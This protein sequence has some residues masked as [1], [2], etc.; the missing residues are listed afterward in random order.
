MFSMNEILEALQALSRS[1]A[2]GNNGYQNAQGLCTG[3]L[4]Q[5][6]SDLYGK[7]VFTVEGFGIVGFGIGVPWPQDRDLITIST[8]INQPIALRI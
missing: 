8:G 1:V 7:S 4:R 2:A 5:D 3:L 6:L